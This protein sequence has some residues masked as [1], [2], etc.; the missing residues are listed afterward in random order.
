MAIGPGCG[1]GEVQAGVENQGVQSDLLHLEN[2]V[3]QLPLADCSRC[4]N[5]LMESCP[6]SSGPYSILLILN[7]SINWIR[8]PIFEHLFD[9]NSSALIHL[10]LHA[11]ALMLKIVAGQDQ[12]QRGHAP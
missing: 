7:W 8:A 2:R 4:R 11:G 12:R 1:P 9:R 5:Q 3:L 6:P 10:Q